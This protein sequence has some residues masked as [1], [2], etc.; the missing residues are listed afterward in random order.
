M[1]RTGLLAAENVT[2]FLDSLSPEQRMMFE[3]LISLGVA[4]PVPPV[5]RECNTSTPPTFVATPTRW[6]SLAGGGAL[7]SDTCN[8]AEKAKTL[9]AEMIATQARERIGADV[10]GVGQ[11][12][13]RGAAGCLRR[14]DIEVWRCRD[15]R[16]GCNLVLQFGGLGPMHVV[17]CSL[18]LLCIS[19][20][21]EPWRTS[22]WPR[23]AG[24]GGRP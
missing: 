2:R 9:L 3:Q 12:H 1:N 5:T 17:T 13:R 24:A 14:D 20:K 7:Q 18:G 23:L 8:T 22:P 16:L 4:S 19:L 21:S 11:A 6:F 15:G 10:C